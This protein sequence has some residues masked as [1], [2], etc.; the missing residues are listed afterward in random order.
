MKL[1]LLTFGDNLNNHNQAI[2]SILSFL[3]NDYITSV[4]VVTDKPSYYKYLGNSIEIVTIDDKKMLTWRGP[5]DFFWR[6]KMKAIETAIKA[7]D[8]DILYVDSDTLLAGK[9]LEIK[10]SLDRGFAGMHEKEGCL[11]QLKSK[12][13]KKMWKSLN[14]KTFSGIKVSEKTEMWNAGVIFMPKESALEM[15]RL[16]IKVCDEMCQTKCTRRLIEQF[17]FSIALGSF[18]PLVPARSEIAHYWGNKEEWNKSIST[19]LTYSTL[20]KTSLSEDLLRIKDFDYTNLA[21]VIKEKNSKYRLLKLI[22]KLMPPK[23]VRF[24]PH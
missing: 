11:C 18:N 14:G 21:T 20:C 22:N 9:L 10:S 3:S 2:F 17:S 19:F 13:E 24:F 4:V 5:Y 6:I 16:A 12:T 1:V 7:G 15:V 23:L 8:E